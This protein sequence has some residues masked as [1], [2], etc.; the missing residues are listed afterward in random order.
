VTRTGD[1]PTERTSFVG[2][3]EELADVERL[4]DGARM[5]TLTGVG[6][7]GKTRLALRAAARMRPAFPDGVWRVQL[8]PLQDGALVSQA[9]AEALGLVDPTLRPQIDVLADYLADR[10]LLLVLDTCEHLVDECAVLTERLLDAAPGLRILATSRRPID[11]LDEQVRVIEPLPESDAI[12]LFVARAADVIPGFTL[13][14]YNRAAAVTL[15]RR[16]DGLPLA[17]ELAAVQLRS[18]SVRQIAT[19]LEDRLL[20]DGDHATPSRHQTLRTTIGW[21][22]ELCEPPERLL[23][24]RLSVFTGDFD[25]QAAEEI[26]GD[27]SLPRAYISCILLELVEK[28][29][30]VQIES[31]TGARFRLLALVREYGAEW[32]RILGEEQAVRRR[33]RDYFLT[34]A[35][36]CA[37]GWLGP[38]QVGCRE[39]TVREHANFRAALDFCL[40]VPEG[41]IGLELAAALWF[42]WFPC[43]FQREGR[44]YLERL[45]VQDRKP[46]L[47]RTWALCTHA[48][49]AHSQGDFVTTEHLVAECAA[50]ADEEGDAGVRAYVHYLSAGAGYMCGDLT[51]AATEAERAVELQRRSGESGY[52]LLH[53]LSVQALVLLARG[54]LDH[55]VAVLEELRAECDKHGELW[56]RSYGDHVRGMVELRRGNVRSTV[57]YGRAA[58]SVK[59]RLNDRVGIGTATDL[60]ACAAAAA[61]DGHRAARLLG[62]AHQVWQSFGLP[63]MGAP[64]FVVARDLCERRARQAIGDQVYEAEFRAGMILDLDKGI[65]YALGEPAESA[66]P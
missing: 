44:H 32:L 7:V 10:R 37:A 8:A 14:D 62:L 33:H 58:L 34:L 65:S 19:R 64:E 6:G 27:E 9:V 56:M 11:A 22:H 30:V 53:G 55:A 46:S 50:A 40:A 25:L 5:V 35:R 17:I 24:A 48:V 60:L 54:E 52:P 1:L 2:R 66:G 61:G 39:G 20:A 29:I 45:L 18:L 47:V 4:F 12:D 28:S 51:R 41:Q 21:S 26:C 3:Q 23:W 59:R 38:D 63:Q 43:G 57:S 16:L 13:S 31:V 36:R 42:F 49:I 15:C